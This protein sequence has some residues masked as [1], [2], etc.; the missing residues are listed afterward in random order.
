[1]KSRSRLL[2][3]IVCSISVS[4]SDVTCELEGNQNKALKIL[5]DVSFKTLKRVSRW[6]CLILS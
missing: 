3:L 6:R 2:H 1:M 4:T 5:Q